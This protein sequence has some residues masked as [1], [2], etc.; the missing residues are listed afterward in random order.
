MELLYLYSKASWIVFYILFSCFSFSSVFL[1]GFST[2][3]CL[4]SCLRPFFSQYASHISSHI[5]LFGFL[6]CFVLV[7]FF[8]LFVFNFF[9]PED[10]FLRCLFAIV[11]VLAKIELAFFIIAYMVI[12][13]GCVPRTVDNTLIF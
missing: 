9:C 1:K 13:F 11:L 5:F 4:F 12:C 10:H 8:C 2:F 3:Y 6:F 7:V